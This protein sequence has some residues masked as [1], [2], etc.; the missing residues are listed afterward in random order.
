MTRRRHNFSK[1][2]AVLPFLLALGC[3]DAAKPPAAASYAAVF[4]QPPVFSRLTRS[5]YNHSLTD[6]FGDGLALPP[7]LEQDLVIAGL[8]AVGSSVA[9]ASLH[10][11]ELYEDA[12]RSAAHQVVTQ[13]K[14]LSSLV[15]C[16]PK[17][18]DDAL[19]IGQV[20]GE[21]GR[22]LWR[23]TLTADEVA[24]GVQ[25]AQKAVKSLGKFE[26]GLEYALQYLLQ[27][28]HFLYRVELGEADPLQ[29]G[30]R[31]LTAAELAAR[32]ALFLWDGPPDEALLEAGQGALNQP[33]VLNAQIERM[34]SDGRARRGVRIFIADWLHLAELETL[35]KDPTVYKHFSADLGASAA[36]ETL[37]LAEYLVFDQPSDFTTLLTS[38]TTFVDRRLAAIYDVP[39]TKD[40]GHGQVLLPDDTPR[41]GFLGHTSFLA[42][43]SHPVSTSP[44]LRGIY[45][46]QVLLCQ[47][48]PNPPAG[49][50]T[51]LPAP[52]TATTLRE[53]LEQ[54]RKD[55]NCAGCHSFTDPMGLGLENFDGIGRY[56]DKDNGEPV[57]ASGE[58]EGAK[59]GD[60]TELVGALAQVADF[61]KCIVRKMLAT[62]LRREVSADEAGALAE[63]D[64]QFVEQGN[65]MRGLIAKIATSSAFRKLAEVK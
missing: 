6:V 53:R 61:R 58:I 59:F 52:V 57:D 28:P 4:A 12:A 64:D 29:T 18:P 56:R 60:F 14:R 7:Q 24:V 1:Q 47:A 55:P 17:S 30:A 45:I 15:K 63:L 10:G 31:R 2:F 42:M 16:Q 44:T 20:V 19:C 21:V 25:I 23:R 46:R 13:P 37:R 5:Q 35:S 27:S 22:K 49:V 11:V 65:R 48:V 8:F 38:K 9:T 41:R 43:R 51:A 62:A 54:H 33:E 26:N 36:E 3:A 50:N 34:L 32:L 39:A 40:V